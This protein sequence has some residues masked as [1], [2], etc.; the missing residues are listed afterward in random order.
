MT[1]NNFLDSKTG[2]APLTGIVYILLLFVFLIIAVYVYQLPP[3]LPLL[4]MISIS[5]F[6]VAL[7]KPDFA[8]VVLIVSM[9]LSPELQVGGIAGRNV[10]FRYDD[11]LIFVIF[12]GW[13]SRIAINKEISLLRPTPLNTPIIIYIAISVFSSLLGALEG[14]VRLQQSFFYITKYVEY[15]ILFFMVANNIRSLRQTKMFT[16]VLIITCLA[17]CVYAWVHIHSMARV[18]APFEGESGE[19]NTLAGYLLFMMSITLGLFLYENRVKWQILYLGVTAF[20]VPPF[21]FTLSRGT[22]IAFFPMSL[23]MM[24]LTKRGKGIIMLALLSLFFLLP[25]LSPQAVKDRI[26]ETFITDQANLHQYNVLGKKFALAQS[27]EDRV[28]TWGEAFK[29]WVKRPFLGYGVPA[30]SIVDNQYARVIREVGTIGFAVYIWLFV[31]I[32]KAGQRSFLETKGNNFAQGLS[33]GFLAGFVGL[34]F[35]S[36]SAETFI[37]IRIMEPFWF[38]AAMVLVIRELPEIS[39]AGVPSPV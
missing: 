37:L 36:F 32:F 6:L 23:M 28:E 29:V 33:L 15:Y 13:L 10:V 18:S 30:S 16:M 5:L 20:M 2:Q 4:L 11:A 25:V 9:L 12:F 27:G 34:L 35:Q 8:L 38:V 24:A 39:Q 22:W 26:A 7:L 21:L 1:A 14:H 31:R 19:A 17:V 3:Y